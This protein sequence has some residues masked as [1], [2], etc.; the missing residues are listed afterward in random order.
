[1]DHLDTHSRM[2]DQTIEFFWNALN[3]FVKGFAFYLAINA[4]AIGYILSENATI[5]LRRVASV[6]GLLT[7]ILYLACLIAFIVWVMNLIRAIHRA[8]TRIGEEVRNA[9]LLEHHFRLGR[10]AIS[11]VAAATVVMVGLV[12]AVYCYFLATSPVHAV[13]ASFRFP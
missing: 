5:E 8:S 9:F 2:W 3:L 12:F 7:S 13:A 6:F 1:M 10:I 11:I 4:A